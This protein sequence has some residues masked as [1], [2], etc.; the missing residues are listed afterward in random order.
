V[1]ISIMNEMNPGY[2]G[3]KARLNDGVK[4]E[5]TKLKR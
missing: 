4:E 2:K 5:T 3:M 1:S